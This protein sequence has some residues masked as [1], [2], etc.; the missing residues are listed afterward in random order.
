MK[1]WAGT[2]FLL[3]VA[4]GCSSEASGVREARNTFYTASA[5]FDV[6]ALKAAVTPDW[7]VVDRDRIINFD[8][9]A[10]DFEMAR[11]E[12]LQVRYTF[13]DS[14]IRVDPPLA[15]MVYRGRKITSRPTA[16]DTTFTI[17]SAAFRRDGGGWRLTLLHR[18]PIVAAGAYF[19]NGAPPAALPAPP[20]SAKAPARNARTG[21]RTTR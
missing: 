17:E 13:A 10:V 8:S 19:E 11:L 20:E 6:A 12:S 16:S 14:T 15:W 21:T 2:G 4:A 5:R 7:L 18:T 9:V 3:L 1:R